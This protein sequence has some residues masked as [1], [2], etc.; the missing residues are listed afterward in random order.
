MTRGSVADTKG[1]FKTQERLDLEIS[2]VTFCEQFTGDAYTF[3]YSNDVFPTTNLE[4][5]TVSYY[6]SYAFLQADQGF[7]YTHELTGQPVAPYSR[8]VG[9]LTGSLVKARAIKP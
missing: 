9:K 5:L 1:L 3:G 2:A 4:Y 6:D 8:T 7:A